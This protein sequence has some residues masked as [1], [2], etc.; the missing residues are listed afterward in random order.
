MAAKEPEQAPAGNSPRQRVFAVTVAFEVKSA[1][2]PEFLALV[3]ENA[4]ASAA[5]EAGCFRFDVLT[6]ETQTGEV[7]LYEIYTDRAAFDLHLRAPH[8]LKFNAA[9]ADMVT[10]KTVRTYN[11]AENAKQA[12][13]GPNRSVEAP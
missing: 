13:L 11:A 6:P 1:S 7:F 5:L 9:T 4:A 8:F 12:G 2:F 10:S 3:N